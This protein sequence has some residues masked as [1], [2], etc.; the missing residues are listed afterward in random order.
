[1]HFPRDAP[2]LFNNGEGLQLGSHQPVLNG[3]DY[4]VSQTF[5]PD[6]VGFCIRFPFV[7]GNPQGANRF[8]IQI[9]LN[10]N[11]RSGRFFAK[12]AKIL[13]ACRGIV[14]G[15][16]VKASLVQGLQNQGV[17]YFD[18]GANNI[19]LM[20]IGVTFQLQ[21]GQ[22]ASEKGQPHEIGL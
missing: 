8:L 18:R 10:D 21:V 11:G 13:Q 14:G 22:V 17:F 5:Q 20:I 4:L 19:G 6:S 3:D 1:M 16:T 15:S 9:K 12:K 7:A 2:A